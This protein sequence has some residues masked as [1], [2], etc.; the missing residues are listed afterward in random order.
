M[1]NKKTEPAPLKLT[2]NSHMPESVNQFIAIAKTPSSFLAFIAYAIDSVHYHPSD[3]HKHSTSLLT[4]ITTSVGIPWVKAPSDGFRA[5]EEGFLSI[6]ERYG[7]EEYILQV[8]DV[9]RAEAVS[10]QECVYKPAHLIEALDNW[11]ALIQI[12]QA[13]Y[14]YEQRDK[15][16]QPD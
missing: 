10:R 11:K 9:I 5:M 16:K 12:G 14:D 4:D 15:M 1:K 7:Y 6:C 3:E 13:V 2:D 8:L